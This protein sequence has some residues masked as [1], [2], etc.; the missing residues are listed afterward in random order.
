M[1]TDDVSMVG[2]NANFKEKIGKGRLNMEKALGKSVSPA[3]RMQQLEIFNGTGP[4][5]Y[6]NDTLEIRM[7]FRNFLN[8]ST[9]LNKLRTEHLSLSPTQSISW[10]QKVLEFFL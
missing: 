9:N 8:P 3:V 2:S 10:D 7:E 1:S 4:F 5:A 6:Y